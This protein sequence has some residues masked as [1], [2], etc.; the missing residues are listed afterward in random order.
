[1]LR[2]KKM[3]TLNDKI[4]EKAKI[5]EEVKIKTEKSVK[6]VVKNIKSK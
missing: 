3:K 5:V 2:D 1:M 4:A 6:K